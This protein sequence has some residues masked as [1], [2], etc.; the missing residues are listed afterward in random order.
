MFLLSM[1]IDV[2]FAVNI[3]YYLLRTEESIE[4]KIIPQ[5]TFQRAVTDDDD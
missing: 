3:C 4:G 2:L 5:W 1:I